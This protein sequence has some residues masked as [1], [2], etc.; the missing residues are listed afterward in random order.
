[1]KYLLSRSVLALAVLFVLAGCT[2]TSVIRSYSS[3]E[4]PGKIQG[5]IVFSLPKTILET[6]IT[7]S[8]YEKKIWISDAQGN[9]KKTDKDMKPI[10]PK[11]ISKIVIIDKPIQVTTKTIADPGMRF[12]FD[13]DSLNGFSKTTDITLE[14]TNNG[15]IK[16]ANSVVQDKSKEIISNA[17]ATLVN[18]AKIAAVA[19][20]DVAELVLIKEVTVSRTIDPSELAFS[21]SNNKF[22]ATYSDKNKATAIFDSGIVVPEVTLRFTGDIDISKSIQIKPDS[23]VGKNNQPG[24]ING[25]PYRVGSP[26]RV[27]ISI[28]DRE[29]Y[30]QFQVF[31]QAGGLSFVPI[32]AKAFSDITQG[33][34][35]SEDGSFITKY[36]S[37]GTSV[38]ESV[39]A[40]GKDTTNAIFTGIKD[41]E[42]TKLDKLKK[43]KEILDA[44]KA[45]D[46]Q[47]SLADTQTKID[48]LKKEKE[49]IDAEIALAESKKK[50]AES[51]PK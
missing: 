47:E 16:S 28:D 39:S 32:S 14:L 3:P 4:T 30:D 27:N 23:V 34:S 35:F 48:K 2:T 19:G 17:T 15:L 25:I 1:M 12:I 46:D 31:A 11:S 10:S 43:E 18:L 20:T 7:Y 21:S 42:Q 37:K 36:A 49:L 38:G 9:P 6:T 13:V 33:I 51:Q 50:Q 45:L 44:R 24:I 26:M 5:G 29:V 8:L 40:A 22:I 41:V